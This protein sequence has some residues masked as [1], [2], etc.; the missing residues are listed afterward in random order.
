MAA[1]RTDKPTRE[2]HVGIVRRPREERKQLPPELEA[3]A[4]GDDDAIWRRERNRGRVDDPRPGS[5]TLVPGVANRDARLVYE[6]RVRRLRAAISDGNEQ[7]LAEELGEAVR[8]GLWRAN[9]VI[10]F[11]VFAE[12]VLGLSIER[13]RSLA[14]RGSESIDEPAEPLEERTVAIWMRAESGLLEHAP[15]AQV[16]LRGGRLLLDLPFSRAA[17]A[18]SGVG[19]RE[20]PFSKAPVGP[21][22]MVDRPAGVSSMSKIIERD[23]PRDDAPS[24][25]RRR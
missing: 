24:D 23:R 3:F 2:P 10:G 6:A 14:I 20:A 1:K 13:A 17:E 19:R 15:D 7:M 16:T 22:T 8:L 5:A 21:D 12:A 25:R 4:G 11:D 18:L 9:N